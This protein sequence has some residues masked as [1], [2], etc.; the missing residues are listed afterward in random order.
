[1]KIFNI[2]TVFLITIGDSTH[3]QWPQATVRMWGR[4]WYHCLKVA[5]LTPPTVVSLMPSM[6]AP[7]VPTGMP[8]SKGGISGATT[9]S[10]WRHDCAW[11]Q[12]APLMPL[13]RHWCLHQKVVVVSVMPPSKCG[14]KTVALPPTDGVAS[15]VTFRSWAHKQISILGSLLYLPISL[16]NH[17]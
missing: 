9:F 15:D 13:W 8:S 4:H 10:C 11:W 1:M 2:F 5:S 7:T 6:V 16:K 14:T 17:L 12:W 3:R